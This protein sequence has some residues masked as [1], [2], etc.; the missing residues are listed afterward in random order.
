MRRILTVVTADGAQHDV[1]LRAAEDT[2]MSEIAGILAQA[3]GV[4]TASPL[5]AGDLVLP[6]DMTLA[7]SPLRDGYRVGLGC[8]VPGQDPLPGFGTRD[9]APPGGTALLTPG[10]GGTLLFHRPPRLHPSPVAFPE[11]SR[12]RWW[13]SRGRREREA[14]QR[15]ERAQQRGQLREHYLLRAAPDAAGLLET[16][17][18]PDA[19]LW[20]RRP[21][22]QDYLRVR[23]GIWDQVRPQ[24]VLPLTVPLGT[25]VAVGIAG[26]GE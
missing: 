15:K 18:H 26:R 20:E 21:A 11:R 22:D 24:G 12:R 5:Y 6:G 10:A 14:A 23:C 17:A 1:D 13:G 4:P 16:A 25:H 3:C 7:E 9:S 19:R 2:P 8:P